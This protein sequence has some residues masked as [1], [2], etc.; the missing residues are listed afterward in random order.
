MGAKLPEKRKIAYEWFSM[1]DSERFRNGLPVDKKMLA[2]RLKVGLTT[3]KD[4]ETRYYSDKIGQQL[5]E[6]GITVKNGEVEIEDNPKD[7]IQNRWLDLLQGAL[8]SAKA[9]NA[10]SQRLLA[11]IGEYL[12]EKQEVT[13]KIDGS[14]FARASIEAE[15]RLRES[16][17]R[18]DAGE[19]EFP[20]LPPELRLPSGQSGGE[21]P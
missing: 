3:V 14:F 15:R 2:K 18:V 5:K 4:W 21:N 13:H 1:T 12:V 19:A 9:G 6:D 17:Y 11:Q 7:W 8:A 10:N 16:G 20:V